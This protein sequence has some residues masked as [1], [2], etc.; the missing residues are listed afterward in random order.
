MYQKIKKIEI[1]CSQQPSESDR[2]TYRETDRKND[3]QKARTNAKTATC[4]R[5][6]LSCLALLPPPPCK[7]EPPHTPQLLGVSGREY[8][9]S[10]SH[11][12]RFAHH[13]THTEI[14]ATD[15]LEMEMEFLTNERHEVGA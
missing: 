2:Q 8:P 1:T 10:A 5:D 11:T 7:G 3:R 9:T 6:E 15:N 4:E 14:Y 12:M 13:F